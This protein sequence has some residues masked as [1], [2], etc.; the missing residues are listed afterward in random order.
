MKNAHISTYFIFRSIISVTLRSV[1]KYWSCDGRTFQSIS[2]A[3]V[4]VVVIWWCWCGVVVAAA[5]GCSDVSWSCCARCTMTG[6]GCCCCMT[7]SLLVVAPCCCSR[8]V[9]RDVVVVNR[10][11]SCSRDVCLS[12]WSDDVSVMH[13]LASATRRL[14]RRLF[15]LLQHTHTINNINYSIRTWSPVTTGMADCSPTGGPHSDKG[16]NKRWGSSA[17]DR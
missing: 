4:V 17:G 8:W 2:W 12:S 9:V 1:I 5:A 14:R 3:V 15:L 11:C 13:V 7:C 6:A 16:I 10:C